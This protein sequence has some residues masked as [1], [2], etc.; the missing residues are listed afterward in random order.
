VGI[1]RYALVAVV[2][3]AWEAAPRLGLVD[4]GFFPPFSAVIGELWAQ[5][6]SGALPRNAAISI[7]R[8]AAGFALAVLAAIPAGL[9]LGTLPTLAECCTPLFM[10]L[11]A[12]NPF[13]LFHVALLFLGIGEAPKITMIAW[14]C[15]WPLLFGSMA[16][17]ARPDAE[18]LRTGRA[19][20]LGGWALTRRVLLPA[21]APAIATSL[22]LSAG[23]AFFVLIAAEMMGA[24]SGLGW[25]VLTYQ[26]S[27]HAARIYAAAVA[28]AIPGLLADSAFEWLERKLSPKE[29]VYAIE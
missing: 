23:L 4:A 17:M 10:V 19:F 3:V 25:L 8:A 27:Y 21:A 13:L 24:S 1:S 7:G 14:V 9:L 22:R 2:L 5:G 16:A 29:N 11:A 15:G 26:E 28:I 18:L 6:V 12:A 20:G